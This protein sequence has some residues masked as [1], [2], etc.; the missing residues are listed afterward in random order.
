MVFFFPFYNKWPKFVK[1]MRSCLRKTTLPGMGR[2]GGE[3]GRLSAGHVIPSCPMQLPRA[4]VL[5]SS[6]GLDVT[7]AG[8]AIDVFEMLWFFGVICIGIEL[9]NWISSLGD[10]Y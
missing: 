3:G 9:L 8:I 5:F 2:E 4:T 1:P 6:H 7:F 10:M